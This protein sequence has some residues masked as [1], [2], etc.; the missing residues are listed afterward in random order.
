MRRTLVQVQL[1]I[2]IRDLVA[3]IPTEVLSQ[4]S[5]WERTQ[6]TTV[7][8]TPAWIESQGGELSPMGLRLLEGFVLGS[9]EVLGR[10]APSQEAQAKVA[11]MLTRVHRNP[12]RRVH[13]R[14]A[15]SRL[16]DT[17]DHTVH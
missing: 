15:E 1:A 17:R 4:L 6:L 13:S 2:E 10:I 5:L 16:R 11:L 14:P 9:L 12:R 7:A 8:E 3:Q